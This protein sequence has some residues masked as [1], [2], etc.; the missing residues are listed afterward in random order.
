MQTVSKTPFSG[1]CA[2]ALAAVAAMTIAS[3]AWSSPGTVWYFHDVV[4]SGGTSLNGNFTT[5]PATGALEAWD[6][7]MN[8]GPYGTGSGYLF[9][10]SIANHPTSDGPSNY[11]ITN[12]GTNGINFNFIDPL[13]SG[14]THVAVVFDNFYC[15][16]CG[17]YYVSGGSGFAATI[18]EP[19]SWAFLLAGFGGM[20]AALRSRRRA[21]TGQA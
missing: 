8:G 16:A 19:A 15:G 6:I 2:G 1:A 11:G 5:N 7:T 20:G 9:S 3:P 12:D 13:N 18:P 21:V 10:S 4:M 14:L 17:G